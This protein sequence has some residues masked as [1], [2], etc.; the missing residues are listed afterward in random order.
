[1]QKSIQIKQDLSGKIR[2]LKLSAIDYLFPLYEMVINSIQSIHESKEEHGEINVM[3]ERDSSGLDF[4]SAEFSGLLQSFTISDN[5]EGFNNTNFDSFCTAD[6][7]YKLALG[8]KG[9]GRFVALKAFESLLIKSTYFDKKAGAYMTR[10][11]GMSREQGLFSSEPVISE[12]K[13]RLTTTKLENYLP[14]FRK[15]SNLPTVAKRLLDHCLIYFINGNAPK[16]LVHDSESGKTADLNK[17]YI[18]FIQQDE[19]IDY[20]QIMDYKFE[21]FYIKKYTEK[22]RHQ[23]HYCANDREVLRKSLS[24]VV[25]NL[26]EQLSDERGKYFLS[27]YVKSPFLDDK[28]YAERNLFNIPETKVKKKLFDFISFEEIENAIVEKIK[29]NYAQELNAIANGKKMDM[30]SYVYRDGLEYR[31]LLAHEELLESIPPGLSDDRLDVELHKVNHKL[32]KLQKARVNK[33][34]ANRNT[35]E[36]HAEYQEELRELVNQ[37]QDLTQAKL[38]TYLTRRKVIIKVLDRFLGVQDDGKFVYE[39][40]IHNIIFPRFKDSKT[41]NYKEHNLWV[42]DER[43]TY[44]QYISSDNPINTFTNG[45][46][47]KEPD[48]I[49]FDKTFA[50][51]ESDLSSI[52]I[53]EFKR[54]MRK[55]TGENKKVHN[56]VIGYVEDLMQAKAVD[57]RGRYNDITAQTPKFGFIICDYDK[58]I[59]EYLM[60]FGDFN[61]TP[62]G[63]LFLYKKGINLMLEVMNYKTL[64]ADVDMRHKAFFKEMGIDRI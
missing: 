51:G 37:E 29:V 30:V 62:K 24:K 18:K 48:L 22:G 38:A 21:I 28:V 5:G 36:N 61:K 8:C 57:A 47:D 44:H 60:E 25:P 53:F 2:N 15:P 49:L 59:E 12:S 63:T 45:S 26:K 23:L 6:T 16:I 7:P 46:S 17:L 4:K 39:K 13:K 50:F 11:L 19:V 41:V 33:F 20:F 42:L 43:L 3:I 27:I 40:E 56:Q 14:D 64:M 9:V 52:V 32:E 34:L 58:E 35:V 31:H 55:L 1:M 10:E 54:P